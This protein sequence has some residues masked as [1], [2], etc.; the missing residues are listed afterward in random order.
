MFLLSG[1]EGNEIRTR[2]IFESG[3]ESPCLQSSLASWK[4]SEDCRAV[5][6]A[7][8]DAILPCNVDTASYD[9]ASQSV[10][11]FFYVHIL[12]SEIDRERFYTAGP[13]ICP[14]V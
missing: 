4:E 12:Q 6:L 1:Y 7:N 8:A 3:F 5:A 9:S 14:N 11:K 2:T 10:S 13:R